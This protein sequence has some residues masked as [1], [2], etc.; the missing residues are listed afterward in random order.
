MKNP[1]IKLL[2][3]MSGG[4]AVSTLNTTASIDDNCGD[5]NG[6]CAIARKGKF[7][8]MIARTLDAQN[9]QTFE[10]STGVRVGKGEIAVEIPVELAEAA[11]F[12][13]K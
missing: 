1:E 6:C 5:D 3:K 7:L 2:S 13:I 11:G 8:Q 4:I 9:T 10:Q 12:S